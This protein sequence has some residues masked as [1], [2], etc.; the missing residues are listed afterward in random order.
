M[1]VSLFSIAALFLAVLLADQCAAGL[2]GPPPYD[3]LMSKINNRGIPV[4]LVQK[5]FKPENLGT[6]EKYYPGK[7]KEIIDAVNK[8]YPEF[9]QPS[10]GSG[11]NGLGSPD[12]GSSGK[13]PGSSERSSAPEAPSKPEPPA[14][15]GSAPP[16][17][18]SGQQPEQPQSPQADKENFGDSGNENV[19]PEDIMD[20]KEKSCALNS[21]N[22]KSPDP[23]S[24]PCSKEKR[25]GYDS[26]SF[27]YKSKGEKD[28][29]QFVQSKKEYDSAKAQFAATPVYP[30]GPKQAALT[31]M[32]QAKAKADA[33]G[34]KC[35]ASRKAAEALQRLTQS[36]PCAGKLKGNPLLG[37]PLDDC[38]PWVLS[39]NCPITD[40][41]QLQQLYND[42]AFMRSLTAK[43][44][45][46]VK[47]MINNGIGQN[48]MTKIGDLN[49]A[50]QEAVLK[51]LGQ[52]KLASVSVANSA[53][54][55]N[56]AVNKAGTMVTD[57]GTYQISDFAGK[58][59]TVN[60][61]NGQVTGMTDQ[62]GATVQQ[63][64]RAQP[65]R[66]SSGKPP[67]VTTPSNP[68]KVRT[69]VSPTESSGPSASSIPSLE[70]LISPINQIVA[71][72]KLGGHL[73]DSLLSGRAFYESSSVPINVAFFPD[74]P[75]EAPVFSIHAGWFLPEWA[76]VIPR[77]NAQIDF[78]GQNGGV[79]T[80]VIQDMGVP[81]G[82]SLM[83]NPANLREK[84][85]YTYTIDGLKDYD[86]VL[87]D[88][89]VYWVTPSGEGRIIASSF[90]V[91]PD[92]YLS[93][94]Q[95]AMV[96]G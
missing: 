49:P 95:K 79:L 5:H 60:P 59:L 68:A 50:L 70:T 18:Q 41:K 48:G 65:V 58:Q 20:S 88:G 37:G 17:D 61:S 83:A 43:D 69:T 87:F 15:Q 51:D 3:K 94:Q 82:S 66:Y 26:C 24:D 4:D 72:Y 73:A 55:N 84:T 57:T 9:A 34:Q 92:E 77:A 78:F 56:L 63:G 38:K 81:M 12:P 54:P 93:S 86:F 13:Q 36:N 6:I 76:E 40:P 1:K 42:R 27:F 16:S 35:C 10:G 52:G 89:L 19:K 53:N 47:N 80:S 21:E 75:P 11:A 71:A 2:F 74:F 45:Q 44:I 39:S 31:K 32:N 96:Y 90:G 46:T 29:K 22:D 14:D 85:I 25:C 62:G 67:K 91:P 23:N 64:E 30:P 33:D 28:C 7:S 8:N